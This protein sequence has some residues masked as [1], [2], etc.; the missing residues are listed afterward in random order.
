MIIQMKSKSYKEDRFWNK[1]PYKMCI[2]KGRLRSTE[3]TPKG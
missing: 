3:V 2:L 1:K